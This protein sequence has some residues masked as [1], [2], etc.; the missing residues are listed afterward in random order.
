MRMIGIGLLG[1]LLASVAL[2]LSSMNIWGKL[3]Q[4]GQS[5]IN[6]PQMVFETRSTRQVSGEYKARI[7]Q[8]NLGHPV[9]LSG[10]P[11]YQGLTFNL[12]MDVRPMSGYLQIEA[13]TQVLTGVEGVLRVSID[14]V[15]RGEVL[16]HPGTVGLSL[17]V[18]LSPSELARQQLV[19][20]I[21]LQGGR[22]QVQCRTEPSIAALVEIESTSAVYLTLNGPLATINDRVN[23]WGGVVRVGWPQWL[24]PNEQARRLLLATKVKQLGIP[25]H[26]FSEN[27]TDAL[28]TKE[29][30]EVIPNLTNLKPA[31]AVWPRQFAKEGPNAG[32]RYFQTATRWRSNFNLHNSPELR[33]PTE[34]DI[35]LALGNQSLDDWWNV[36]VTLNGRLLKHVI[37]SQAATHFDA[38]IKLSPEMMRAKNVI[39]VSA[40]SSRT[41][42][43]NC[44]QPP[45][46]IAE[47]LPNTSLI[48][49]DTTFSDALTV[50]RAHLLDLGVL[51]VGSVANLSTVDAAAASDLL[52]ELLP[53]GVHLKP[54]TE[55][56]DIVVISPRDM[57]I[58]LPDAAQVW[59]VTRDTSTGGIGIKNFTSNTKISSQGL[60]L[61]IVVDG[62]DL[63]EVAL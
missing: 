10:L 7:L 14:N 19:V 41:T 27:A 44:N 24:N 61:L 22:P 58:D 43:T 50:L 42:Q 55:T 15:R 45:R 34:L 39:E 21:S 8:S 11:A 52:A 20:S 31:Y 16:L 29:L 36:T 6:H 30:R 46:L 53:R 56:L 12:P 35:H 33:V 2:L 59:Y 49:G 25:A 54:E 62:T 1:F 40:S 5:Q 38:L 26:F 18:P 28:S 37:L 17:Q 23:A 57:P 4:V 51:R 63:A 13:T 48:L 32:L 9:I 3:Q 60:G 47:M